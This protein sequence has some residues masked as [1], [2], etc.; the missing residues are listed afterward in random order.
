MAMLEIFNAAS[1]LLVR[2]TVCAALVVFT[3]WF[4]KVNDAGDRFAT[5]P[6]PVPLKLTPGRGPVVLLFKPK[7]P[8]PVPRAVGAK[9]TFTVQVAP[10]ATDVPQLF[11]WAKSPAITKV[12]IVRA[13]L[14]VLLRV[15]VCA[16]LEVP[17]SCE[18]KVSDAGDNDA[19]A[20][21]P[22]PFRVT[23]AGAGLLLLD[24]DNDP[25][26]LPTAV[27]VKTILI[28]QLAPAPSD[29]PHVFVWL[30]SP[31]T[32]SDE[33]EREV[34][35]LLVSVTSC[36]ALEL[37]TA[38]D[39]NA[40]DEGESVATAAEPV[41]LKLADICAGLPLLDNTT[42]PKRAPDAEG[43]KTTL[44]AQ[45]APAASDAPQLLVWLKSPV[46]T[47]EEI[48]RDMFPLL[49]SVIVWAV[50]EVPTSCAAKVSDE[51]DN[52]GSAA[53]PV[54]LRLTGVG[55]LL[56]LLVNHID[57]V[58]LPS[59][60]GLKTTL[61]V[62]L[63]PA[64]SDVPQLF[65]WL[66]SLLLIFSAE[67]VSAVLPLL[68]SATVCGPLEVPTAC[69][70]KLR[71]KGENA[72]T[73][74]SPVPLKT[75]GAG[76]GLLLLVKDKDPVRLPMTVGPKTTLIVQLVPAASVAPQLFVWLKSPVT[77]REVMERSAFPLLV[78]VTAC[79]GLEVPSIC[80]AKLSD[81]GE[82]AA[83]TAKPVPFSVM[84]D[85]A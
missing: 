77:F 4:A 30:K 54:P 56:L 66:K 20:P 22:V 15:T 85:G 76:A 10:A 31:V 24:N 75:T 79:D 73:A 7:E 48:A 64:P 41:P 67:M 21:N 39:G 33:I 69:E 29:V 37:P 3:T 82:N 74:A 16:E 60:A 59:A 13:V 55:A 72:G 49:V 42:D 84:G 40:R 19:T 27:G 58:W 52:A 1:P 51:G 78:S 65:V 17:T 71:D 34:F 32:I 53:T 38:C 83:I 14:P 28:E 47:S 81:A 70:A 23:A 46:V 26:R 8:L 36:T 2:V 11:V 44:I 43:L 62:Q 12:L 35:P 9:V 50:L 5:G 25:L 18:P 68:E 63:A 45:L 61:M 6:M 57:P 80:E